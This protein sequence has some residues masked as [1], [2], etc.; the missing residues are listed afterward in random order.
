M[1]IRTVQSQDCCNV[2]KLMPPRHL[3]FSNFLVSAQDYATRILVTDRGI[4]LGVPVEIIVGEF[5]E[6]NSLSQQS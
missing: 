5:K 6:K 1:H 4:W 3:S 2:F